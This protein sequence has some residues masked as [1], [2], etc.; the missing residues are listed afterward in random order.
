[1][2]WILEEF[3]RAFELMLKELEEFDNDETCAKSAL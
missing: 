2:D 3:D 1:M